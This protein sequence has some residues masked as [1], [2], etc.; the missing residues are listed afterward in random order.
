MKIKGGDKVRLPDGRIVEVA[1]IINN[2]V[3]VT[4]VERYDI[5]NVTLVEKFKRWGG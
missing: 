1:D 5:E 4:F 2:Q 3:V